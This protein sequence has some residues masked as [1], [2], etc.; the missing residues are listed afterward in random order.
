MRKIKPT[1]LEKELHRFTNDH[2]DI[3]V[4]WA[5]GSM[6]DGTETETSDIAIGLSIFYL[7]H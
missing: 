1:D 7:I 5:Y 3:N 4:V 6:V 2:D